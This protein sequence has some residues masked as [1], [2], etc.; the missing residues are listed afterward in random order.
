MDLVFLIPVAFFA[1]ITF[2]VKWS[3]DYS[4]WKRQYERDDPATDNSLGTGELLA[5]IREAVEDANEPLL[6][7]I[8]ALEE[9]LDTL[10]Q[11]RL[12]TGH[13]SLLD[14]LPEM[15]QAEAL[16][17]AQSQPVS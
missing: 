11:P 14:D 17:R 13:A 15:D 4:R 9:R 7:R 10:A 12:T 8:E 6:D 1:A 16:P 2:I 5:L 3:L